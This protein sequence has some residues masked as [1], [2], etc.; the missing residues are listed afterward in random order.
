E[1]AHRRLQFVTHAIDVHHQ[2][3]R[4]LV[5]DDALESADH[6]PRLRKSVTANPVRIAVALMCAWVRATASASAA[7]ACSFISARFSNNRTMCCTCNLSAAPRPTSD[8][9]MTRGAY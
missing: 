6:V 2:P 9:L 3:R 1:G 4:L 5:Y 8:C 7:S